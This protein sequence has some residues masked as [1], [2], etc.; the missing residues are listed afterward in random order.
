MYF[1]FVN[2]LELFQM[3]NSPE[4]LQKALWSLEELALYTKGGSSGVRDDVRVLVCNLGDA[5]ERIMLDK[6]IPFTPKYLK[7]SILIQ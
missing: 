1:S 5:G 4:Y 3:H 2:N 6:G 7:E